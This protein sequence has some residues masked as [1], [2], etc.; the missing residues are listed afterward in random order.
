MDVSM[1]HPRSRITHPLNR[2]EH[3]VHSIDTL[4]GI[5]TSSLLLRIPW[6]T[7]MDRNLYDYGRD[8][9][10]LM[11]HISFLSTEAYPL[12]SLPI[13][14]CIFDRPPYMVTLSDTRIS[15]TAQNDHF[16][17]WVWNTEE[18]AQR[19]RVSWNTLGASM[20]YVSAVSIYSHGECT[21]SHWGNARSHP[22]YFPR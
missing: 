2:D 5:W 12:Y 3:T 20:A 18:W 10:Y 4:M 1:L 17:E 19:K 16:S 11:F 14:R 13:T 7:E 15:M 22:S 8:R 21:E 9:E 6:V